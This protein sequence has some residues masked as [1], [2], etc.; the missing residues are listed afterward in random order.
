MVRVVYFTTLWEK[1][2]DDATTRDP[3]SDSL[4]TLFPGKFAYRGLGFGSYVCASVGITASFTES[5]L[6]KVI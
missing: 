6:V 2:E 3:F 1:F 4:V 5:G